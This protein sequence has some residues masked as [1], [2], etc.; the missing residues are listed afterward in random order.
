MV[1]SEA[2]R[3]LVLIAVG[4]LLALFLLEFPALVNVLDYNRMIGPGAH[5]WATNRADPE[6]LHIGRPY[7][8]IV[9]QSRGGLM[10]SGYQI[11][12]SEMTLFRYDAKLDRNGFRNEV[13]LESVD[14]VVIGDSM[15]EGLTVPT[16]E[17]MTS[18]LAHLQNEVVANLGQIDYGPQQELIVLKRYGLPLRP[19]A[20]LWMFYEGNDLK[21]VV[22]YDQAM[23]NA[24]SFSW[25]AFFARSFTKNALR[26]VKRLLLPAARPPGITRAG[27]LQTSNGKKLTL[28]FFFP[29]QPLTKEDLSALDE[30]TRILAEA[31]K[32]CAAQGSR[33]IFVFVPEAFRVFQGFCQ[34]PLESNCR[35]WVLSDLPER[36]RRAVGSISSDI[37]Y[38]DLTP[39]LVEAVKRGA[40]PYD[41]DDPHWSPE[42]HKIAADAINGYLLATRSQ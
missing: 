29:S 27:V 8:H 20:V 3:R 11:P 12:P 40:I 2:A 21:D 10:E 33:L 16:P 13:D 32:L 17:L 6:L 28:Y 23:R 18:L 41:S 14:M 37:G 30:T 42:G 7:L 26:G 36:M 9:G 38:L 35:Q 31:Q 22:D 1:K 24:R 19:R 4:L 34:F 25:S 39:N 5:W 15:V